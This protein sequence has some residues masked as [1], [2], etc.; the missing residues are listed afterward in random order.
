M[1]DGYTCFQA[2][3]ATSNASAAAVRWRAGDTMAVEDVGM[4][5]P[6][7]FWLIGGFIVVAL[8]VAIC[9]VWR[10]RK[11][12]KK[13]DKKTKRSVKTGQNPDQTG[14]ADEMQ[15]NTDQWLFRS[16]LCRHQPKTPES[17]IFQYL[18]TII[19]VAAIC[20]TSMIQAAMLRLF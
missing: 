5:V 8:L 10:S 12:N 1:V 18:E 2:M 11:R 9:V 7:E 20:W 4:A 13:D 15:P 16:I 17:H 19:S 6:S 14:S 3:P